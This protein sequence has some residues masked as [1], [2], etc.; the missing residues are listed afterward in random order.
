MKHEEAIAWIKGERSGV[1][2]IPQ[3]PIET[4]D[5]RVAQYDAAWTEKAYWILRAHQD[6]H[7]FRKAVEA[8]QK[9]EA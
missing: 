6:L 8:F 4:F 2:M 7:D 3:Y 1:N 9:R 5:V